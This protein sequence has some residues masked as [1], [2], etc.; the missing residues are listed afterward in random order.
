MTFEEM[1]ETDLAACSEFGGK[2]T[3]TFESGS[4]ELDY[5][6]FD[7]KTDVILEKGEYGGIEATIPTLTVQTTVAV[8]INH[9]SSIEVKNVVYEV[10]EVHKLDD[11]TTI[12]YL[13]K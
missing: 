2:F 12:I 10:T 7:E 5:L 3:H 11:S 13:G 1:I 9:R 4:V 6:C 8:S